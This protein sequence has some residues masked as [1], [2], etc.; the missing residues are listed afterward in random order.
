MHTHQDN[1]LELERLLEDV[2][3]YVDNVKDDTFGAIRLRLKRHLLQD[4]NFL[5]AQSGN[6]TA[7][8]AAQDDNKRDEMFS[9]EKFI[10]G[11]PINTIQ[12]VTPEILTPTKANTI[13]FANEVAD[14]YNGFAGLKDKDLIA[15][16]N[17]PKGETLLRGVAKKA[18]VHNWDSIEASDIDVMFL[19]DIREAIKQ[20][21]RGEELNAAIDGKIAITDVAQAPKPRKKAAVRKVIAEEAEEILD[22]ED[23]PDEDVP[24]KKPG[25]KKI[26][27]EEDE[28]A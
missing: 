6:V 7:I 9:G 12:P 5:R 10:M 17:K 28:D 27:D 19:A 11:R 16:L 1:I 26:T 3:D 15:I 25:K 24:A 18:N 4:L 2:L 23:E 8:T 14:L 20:Q 13:K 22:E 21:V